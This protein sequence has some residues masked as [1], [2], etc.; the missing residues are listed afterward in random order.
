MPNTEVSQ[1][2]SMKVAKLSDVSGSDK[3]S[4]VCGFFEWCE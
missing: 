4:F 3:V 2:Q 1:G